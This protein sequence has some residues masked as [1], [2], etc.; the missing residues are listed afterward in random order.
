MLLRSQLTKPPDST[1]LRSMWLS[2]IVSTG[3]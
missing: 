1:K 2:V 3:D